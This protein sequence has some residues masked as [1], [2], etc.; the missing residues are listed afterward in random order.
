M[1]A[2]PTRFYRSPAVRTLLLVAA[3]LLY[4]IA[5]LCAWAVFDGVSGETELGLV[6]A[7]LACQVA[8]AF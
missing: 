3:L 5:A 6:A 1:N 7:G 8:A 2:P 4:V